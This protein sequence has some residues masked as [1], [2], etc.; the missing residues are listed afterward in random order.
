MKI[1]LYKDKSIIFKS[2]SEIKYKNKFQLKIYDFFYEKLPHQGDYKIYFD[3]DK[4]SNIFL[5]ISLIT[6]TETEFPNCLY[7][8]TSETAFTKNLSGKP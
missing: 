4:I 2:P 6:G 5:A 1:L 3:T 8:C 7:I